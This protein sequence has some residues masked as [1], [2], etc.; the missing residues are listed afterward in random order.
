MNKHDA[1]DQ[2]GEAQVKA[3][4]RSWACSPP[5]AQPAGTDSADTRWAPDEVVLW[6]G[7]AVWR[8]G[9]AAF[10]LRGAVAHY[11]ASAAD[12]L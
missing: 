11:N 3:W 7:A 5:L 12:A 6:R 4:R 2:Y 10:E 1:R 9:D 8:V